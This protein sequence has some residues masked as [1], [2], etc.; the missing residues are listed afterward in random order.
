MN[1]RAASALRVGG[2]L[3][4]LAVLVALAHRVEWRPVLVTVRA[5]DPRLL[6]L[7][8][9]VNLASLLL[10]GVRWWIFL[11]VVGASSIS[12]AI[13]ATFV[14]AALN[15]LLVA[16]GG[17]GARVLLVSR[18]SGA[19]SARVFA[20][21]ALERLLDMMTYLLLLVAAVS[22]LE[23]P[24]GIARWRPLAWTALGI[25]AVMFALFA[26]APDAAVPPSR[27]ERALSIGERIRNYGRGFTGGLALGASPLRLAAALLLSLG[28]WAL[29]VATYHLAA[30]AGH[31]PIPLA[32]SIAAL[33][34]IGVSFLVRAT[35]G[36]VG[37][38]QVAYL[39][40]ARSFGMPETPALAV[41]ILIQA[42]QVGPTLVAG[43]LAAP[44]IGR[45]AQ[46]SEGRG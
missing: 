17:E 27:A 6:V 23:L 10:K 32:G 12:L 15:N 25:L 44:R 43:L 33:L 34:V 13:R 30:R 37:V 29:Q 38:F 3:A 19:S 39:L 5:A 45:R 1:A 4:I 35:P 46:G 26:R 24:W 21:L 40:A 42:L 14:G 28:A 16:Q 2:S 20:A 22:M 31:L 7:A 36:N 9:I 11:R 8:A 18:A 41:A